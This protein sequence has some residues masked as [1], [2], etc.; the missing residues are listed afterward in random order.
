MSFAI[1]HPTHHIYKSPSQQRHI[2]IIIIEIDAFPPIRDGVLHPQYIRGFKGAWL[3]RTQ[4]SEVAL[5][6]FLSRTFSQQAAECMHGGVVSESAPRRLV[7][8]SFTLLL[9]VD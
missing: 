1:I 6:A 5:S 8:Q 9:V 4:S 3:A 2:I 7:R